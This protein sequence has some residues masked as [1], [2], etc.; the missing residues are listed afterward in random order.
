MNRIFPKTLAIMLFTAIS[1]CTLAQAAPKVSVSGGARTWFDAPQDGSNLPLAPYPVVI[2]AYDPGGVA[3]VELSVNG[4]ILENLKP[5]DEA[6]L[7]VFKYSWV[8]KQTGNYM[9]RARSQGQGKTWNSEAIV[10]VII[11]EITPTLV[12]SFTPTLVDT[13]TPTAVI[14]FTPT[15]VS[16]F[17]PSPPPSTK[18]T[19]K[20]NVSAT[21]IYYGSCGPN[22]L[23]IQAYA[24]DT[25]LVRGIT[26]FI[27]LKDQQSGASIGWDGGESM[28][29]AGNGWFQRTFSA[30]SIPNY[31]SYTN[32]WILYQFVATGSDGSIVGRS[33][34]Y[35]DVALSGCD[36]PPPPVRV[37]PPKLVITPLI[38]PRRIPTNTYIPSP[39]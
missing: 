19:F 30:T 23:T 21:Q 17:T 5:S 16:S 3:Q 8:P 32:A 14:S 1:A 25:N 28:N 15:L 33:P 20:A 22:S 18:L 27:N 12:S 10:N 2:H 36:A 37:E 26:L 4:V 9:L 35:S 39:K 29:P 24:S 7:S 13:F 6:G 34:V 38:I 11:G 31:N